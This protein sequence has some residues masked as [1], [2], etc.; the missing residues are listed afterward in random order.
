M[1][2]DPSNQKYYCYVN[3]QNS[4]CSDK[5]L[6]TRLPNLYLSYKACECQR[7]EGIFAADYEYGENEHV[8]DY[9]NY[10]NYENYE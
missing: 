1:A 10:D 6:S 4:G 8:E 9:E 5:K 7:A 2:K 3:G